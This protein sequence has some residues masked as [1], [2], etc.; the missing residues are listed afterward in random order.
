MRTVLAIST[1][2]LAATLVAVVV[3]AAAVGNVRTQVT[4]GPTAL[5]PPTT[6]EAD[7][8]PSPAPSL[9]ETPEL[10]VD[11]D[12]PDEPTEQVPETTTT[13]TT[14][15]ETTTSVPSSSESSVTTTTHAPPTTTVAAYTK[16]YNVTVDGVTAGTV[17]IAVSGESVSF[18]GATV[19]P[20]WKFE[21]DED[22]PEKVKVKF[23]AIEDDD[24]KFEFKAEIEDGELEVEISDDD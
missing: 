18:S 16:T 22:G 1:A 15:V 7:D 2:W 20:G 17:R 12:L 5:G 10:S 4:D 24:I 23:K 8:D 21:L 3:A 14:I 9:S 19:A 13:S 11:I 6:I